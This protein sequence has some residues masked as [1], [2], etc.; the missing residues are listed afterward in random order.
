MNITSYLEI[1][2]SLCQEARALSARKG[3]DYSGEEDTLR[4]LKA[5]ELLGL[6]PAEEG[7]LLRMQDKM[8][9]LITLLP[10]ATT[11]RQSATHTPP[12]VTAP[13]VTESIK[14]TILDL[15][16]YC[17][18]LW[19]LMYE[20]TESEVAEMPKTMCGIICHEP[21]SSTHVVH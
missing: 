3:H 21:M 6:C 20:Q 10:N 4:N 8:S 12:M 14:D 9:R 2:E 13:M 11:P 15:L 17:V 16:N 7:V 1:H 19:A 18:L 5:C